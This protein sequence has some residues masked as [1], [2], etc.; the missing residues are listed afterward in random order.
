MNQQGSYRPS[1]MAGLVIISPWMYAWSTMPL[2]PILLFRYGHCPVASIGALLLAAAT[3]VYSALRC[4]TVGFEILDDEIVIRNPFRAYR[5][6]IDHES[7]IGPV[8]LEMLQGSTSGIGVHDGRRWIPLVATAYLR[9]VDRPRLAG[10]VR[11]L[12]QRTDCAVLVHLGPETSGRTMTTVTEPPEP[13]PQET[14]AGYE[15]MH[16]RAKWLGPAAGLVTAAI[17][18]TMAAWTAAAGRTPWNLI[19]LGAFL[20]I[21]WGVGLPLASHRILRQ[22]RRT[23]T[24]PSAGPPPP[25]AGSGR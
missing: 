19:V 20:L 23:Q 13:T 14:L 11:R 22:A 7:A 4:W 2:V 21:L 17:P 10:D 25:E 18:W 9:K 16:A 5:V 6:R 8:S 24:R 1:L 3:A 12:Q 15:Q